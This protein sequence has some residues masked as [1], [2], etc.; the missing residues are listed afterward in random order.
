MKPAEFDKF[1]TTYDQDMANALAISGQSHDFF[2]QVK[3]DLILKATRKILNRDANQCSFLDVGCGVGA[4]A[5]LLADKVGQLKGVDTSPALVDVANRDVPSGEFLP[6]DG[7]QMPFADNSFDVAFVICVMHHVPPH[8]WQEFSAEVARV[9]N[10]GGLV[11]IFEHNQWN[12]ATMR[13][14][15]ACVF[16]KDAVLLRP[17][18]VN[19]LLSKAGL[20]IHETRYILFSPFKG[21][22]FRLLDAILHWLPFGAQY[23]V[24]ACKPSLCNQE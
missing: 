16:D 22:F 1:E 13:I 20:K 12:P 14:V 3:V 2:M 7:H 6:Y 5:K 19:N 17:R 15:N 23:Y 4:T 8:Q 11:L 9:V 18:R 24:A 21:Y 10:P